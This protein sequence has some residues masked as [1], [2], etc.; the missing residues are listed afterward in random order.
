MSA[1]APCALALSPFSV[2]SSARR[3]VADLEENH[4]RLV[5]SEKDLRER[6]RDAMCARES[7]ERDL[8][9]AFEVELAAFARHREDEDERRAAELQRRAELL[10]VRAKQA[11]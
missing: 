8:A 4:A 3:R 11:P 6:A 1:D 5:A 7:C 2:L 10:P 9:K